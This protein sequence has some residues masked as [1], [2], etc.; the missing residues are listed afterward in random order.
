MLITIRHLLF[1]RLKAERLK[2]K[3]QDAYNDTPFVIYEA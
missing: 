2:L 3:A 1:M